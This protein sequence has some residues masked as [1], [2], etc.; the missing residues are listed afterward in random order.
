MSGNLLA[1]LRVALRLTRARLRHKTVRF[2]VGDLKRFYAELDQAGVRYL[3][4]RWSD[5]VPLDGTAY[6]H[7][8]DHLFENG[9]LDRIAAIA[10]RH[11]GPYQC[12][13][14]G[15]TGERGGAYQ[16]MP[17][18]MP[19]LAERLLATRVRNQRG[20][21]CPA[22]REALYSY[23]YHLAYHKG[24]ACGLP[25]GVPGVGPSGNAKRDYAA[26]AVRLA[27]LAGET[28]P[29]PL[30]LLAIDGW[31]QRR[32]WGMA[33]DLLPRWPDRH[34]MIELIEEKSRADLQELIRRCRGLN[35]FIPRTDA[36]QDKALD[37][38]RELLGQYFELIEEGPLSAEAAERVVEQTRGGNWVEKGRG[39]VGPWH[40][41][42]GRLIDDG[43]M[44]QLDMS[45]EK[46][47]KRYPEIEH[48]NILVKRNV[49]DLVST[50]PG[51][52]K[53]ATVIHST[54]NAFET[55]TTLRAIY[56]SQLESFLAGIGA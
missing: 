47:K 16:G 51:V 18:Y 31:L 46:L 42:V 53:D 43:R 4:L 10:A 52:R 12:D 17:Y 40:Y 54:D 55:A 19:I 6:P 21:W 15:E 11:P 28:L 56:G 39:K 32:G 20:V 50:F 29:Q 22:P 25:S 38:A 37:A 5:E 7:D 44:L 9:A 48:R 14:Y 33:A 35:V 23:L 41:F 49:R 3:V 2:Y 8:V 24:L 26:E 1:K 36:H 30:D 27:A 13:W 34:Q 45:D